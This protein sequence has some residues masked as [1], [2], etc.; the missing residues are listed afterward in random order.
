LGI[1]RARFAVKGWSGLVWPKGAGCGLARNFQ[2][3]EVLSTKATLPRKRMR[4]LRFR[5][6]LPLHP[7]QALTLGPLIPIR[8]R[9]G[10]DDTAARADHRRAE[11][12]HRR[13][14][15]GPPIGAQ[16]RLVMA[17]AST[18]DTKS[19]PLDT[20]I[21]TARRHEKN[22]ATWR[23]VV[24]CVEERLTRRRCE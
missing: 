17:R 13:H 3:V 10:A 11:A 23:G 12:R 9:I 24:V 15:I 2:V 20:G 6:S 21:K 4:P 19:V 8:P 5:S 22:P 7:R 1:R 18:H 14:G 16:H